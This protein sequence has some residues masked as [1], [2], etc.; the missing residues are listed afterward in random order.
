MDTWADM[1]LEPFRGK[2]RNYLLKSH[3]DSEVPY[4]WGNV[5]LL[6]FFLPAV[7]FVEQKMLA[8][9]RPSWHKSPCP[10]HPKVCQTKCATDLQGCVQSMF[11]G[12]L[13][14]SGSGWF[15]SPSLEVLVDSGSKKEKDNKS[16]YASYQNR[17]NWI[18]IHPVHIPGWH[19]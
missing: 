9:T 4:L 14:A 7:T 11:G 3:R 8:H 13:H 18:D 10:P 15:L 5:R 1:N 6:R 16:P 2:G 19:M 17:S 12:W